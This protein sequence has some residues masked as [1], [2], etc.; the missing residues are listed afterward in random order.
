MYDALTRELRAQQDQS[1]REI[2]WHQSAD[3]S[4]LDQGI[5]LL[6]LANNASRLFMMEGPTERRRLL[7]FVV[8]NTTWK[9]GELSVKLRQ[10]FDLIAETTAIVARS[11]G[12]KNANP[13]GHQGWLGLLNTF[14]TMCIAPPPQIRQVFEQI[15]TGF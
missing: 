1:L 7:N 8:S 6:Q 9:N 5:Q 12:G 15:R 4:Y 2:G 10:P 13:D 14:R 3:Q 11:N